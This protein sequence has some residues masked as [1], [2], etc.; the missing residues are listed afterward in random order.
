MTQVLMAVV[1][2]RKLMELKNSGVVKPQLLTDKA[3]VAFYDLRDMIVRSRQSTEKPKGVLRLL[4]S[5][6]FN[7]HMERD[8][9]LMFDSRQSLVDHLIAVDVPTR[10]APISDADKK[11]FLFLDRAARYSVEAEKVLGLF[12]LH[13]EVIVGS[14]TSFLI[15][16]LLSNT[17]RIRDV[18]IGETK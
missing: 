5:K 16:W 8:V 7:T 9:H 4:G 17:Q 15:N 12:K 11:E 6:G 18:L 13:N 1:E 3:D 10:L 14:D 2:H